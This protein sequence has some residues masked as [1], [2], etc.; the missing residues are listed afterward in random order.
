MRKTPEV[1][2]SREIICYLNDKAGR[3]FKGLKKDRERIHARFREGF[4]FNDFIQVIDKKVGEWMGTTYSKFLRPETLFGSKFEGY[5]QET[6]GEKNGNANS[7]GKDY[8]K[9]KF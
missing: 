8:R 3:A 1:D 7:T 9:G 2:R 6:I 4:T 5:L